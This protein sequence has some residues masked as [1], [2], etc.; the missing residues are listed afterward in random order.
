MIQHRRRLPH[1]YPDS[2]NSFVTWSLHG[3]LPPSFSARP[4]KLAGGQ[5]FVWMD[6]HL[7]AARSGPMHLRQ[8]AIAQLVVESIRKGVQLGHYQLNAFVVVANHVHILIHP[9]IDPSKLLKA[10]KGATARKANKL[11]RRTGE[12]FWQ[13]ESYD[14]WVR[15]SAE[16][17]RIT[18]YIE[19]NPVRAGL[20]R[21]PEEY[22][23][24]SASVERSG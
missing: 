1:V 4:G 7:D 20:A 2:T 18:A 5:A 16:F 11:L 17:G 9:Q 19:T 8:P 23:W 3:A 24:S 22:P 10:L 6:R 15:D 13:K 21:V 14:H 12:P